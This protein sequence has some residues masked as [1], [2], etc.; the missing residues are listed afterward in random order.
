[1]HRNTLQRVVN[2]KLTNKESKVANAASIGTMV[3]W[4]NGQISHYAAGD[5]NWENEMK[6]K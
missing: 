3:V 2:T 6:C 4:T 5:M 1:M